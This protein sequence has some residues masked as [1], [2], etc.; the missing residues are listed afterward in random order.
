MTESSINEAGLLRLEFNKPIIK[1]PI[2]A[3]KNP[4]RLLEKKEKN[5]YSI[6][7]VLRL[8]VKSTNDEEV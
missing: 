8:Q 1:P 5:V 7:E 2:A 3:S 4:E 6:G